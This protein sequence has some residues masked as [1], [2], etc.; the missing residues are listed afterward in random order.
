MKEP[1]SFGCVHRI[2]NSRMFDG[3]VTAIVLLWMPIQRQ[4][5]AETGHRYPNFL[6]HWKLTSAEHAIT[7]IMLKQNKDVREEMMKLLSEAEMRD[8]VLFCLR[9]QARLAQRHEQAIWEFGAGFDSAYL[10]SDQVRVISERNDDEQYFWVS[11]ASDSFSVQKD[12]EQVHGEIERDIQIICYLMEDQS[13]FLE[14]G[15]LKNLVKRHPMS[16]GFPIT[17]CMR[18]VVTIEPVKQLLKDGY[19]NVDCVDDDMFAY[20]DEYGDN[21][22]SYKIGDTP[23]VSIA[24]YCR[25]AAKEVAMPSSMHVASLLVGAGAVLLLG[26]HAGIAMHDKNGGC[27]T[28]DDVP[29]RAE[30]RYQ[31]HLRLP[32]YRWR[33][34]N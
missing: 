18:R 1:K 8:A 12:T 2:I 4:A 30:A 14:E 13:K 15:C 31:G 34:R 10:V 28:H 25:H 5:H 21:E 27:H 16:I 20:G 22:F 9:Q 23:D 33:R 7:E 26:R 11:G 17:S 32:R 29:I 3:I 19:F 24:R 6:R